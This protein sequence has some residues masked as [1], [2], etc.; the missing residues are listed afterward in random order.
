MLFSRSARRFI[1]SVG[2]FSP[3]IYYFCGSVQPADLLFL[4]VGSAR[5]FIVSVGRFSPPIYHVCGS[6][7]HDLSFVAATT[8]VLK[9]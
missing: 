3:P 7:H 2:R 4:W 8:L 9:K 1:I 5:R 6:V